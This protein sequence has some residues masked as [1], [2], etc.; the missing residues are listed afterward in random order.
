MR[1]RIDPGDRRVVSMWP[2]S[3]YN[4]YSNLC[5]TSSIGC[6]GTSKAICFLPCACEVWAGGGDRLRYGD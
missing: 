6:Y 2:F 3:A 1:E 4:T 5:K